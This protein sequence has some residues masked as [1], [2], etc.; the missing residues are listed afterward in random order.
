MRFGKGPHISDEEFFNALDLDRPGLENVRKATQAG[1]WQMAKEAFA[2]HMRRRKHP[3]WKFDWRARPREKAPTYDTTEAE[4]IVRNILTSVSVSHD[5]GPEGNI[6]WELNPINYKEWTWQLSRHPF[7]VTLGEAYWA[8]GDERYTQAFVRQMMHWVTNV[9]RPDDSGNPWR[10]DRTNCWRTI[11][12]G[13]RMGRTWF[14]A[15]YRFLS[16]PHFT[17]EAICMMVKS[18]AEHARHLLKWP[19]SGNWLTM[20]ANGLYHVGVMFP[21]FR[22]AAEWRSVGME[23]LHKELDNQVYPDG[24]QIEL[25]SGY[26]QVSLNNFVWAWEIGQVNQ[27]EIPA[28]YVAKLERMYHYDLYLSMPDGRMPALNDGGY[29]VIKPYMERS[30]AFFP[31]RADFRWA[32]SDGREGRPP[33]VTSCEFPYAG[34]LVTR[35]GWNRDDRYLFFDAGPFGYGHQHEDKLN[36]VL[37]AYG[38][39]LIAD[40][41]NYPYDDSEWRKYVLSTRGHNTIRV[42]GQDQHERGRPRQEYV[43][44]EPLPHT[45]ISGDSFDYAA[46][47]FDQGYG[48]QFSTQPADRTVQ[49][50]RKILFVKPDFWLMADFL[51]SSD[52]AE[53]T[54]ESLFHLDVPAARAT[55]NGVHTLDDG[56]PKLDIHVAASAPL[57][58]QIVSGQ[59]EPEVQGWIPR[60]GPYE[61]QP[62]P[63]AV[64]RARWSGS[65]AIAYLLYPLPAGAGDPLVS[66]KQ[67]V[68]EAGGKPAIGLRFTLTN[69]RTYLYAQRHGRDGLMRWEGYE[70]DAEAALI[71]LRDGRVE[72]AIA[73]DGQFARQS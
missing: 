69:G 21:E 50:H 9:P 47:S 17:P 36:I 42:D 56:G 44:K 13:I 73:A 39:V 62:I 58:K 61:C 57:Q 51:T 16:S 29:T 45:W 49:H 68:V 24:A 35:S 2:A 18:M 70:S 38:K 30:L 37:Y 66:F 64:F 65:M 34:H 1:D 31:R 15:F 53:H 23:R 7:W 11:E 63:T 60:G 19:Q 26:H 41:G 5:F 22:E 25:S 3:L 4:R 54:A 10:E 72:K 20:E 32:A 67:V 48:P 52:E 59:K 71:E 46:A 8:T 43:V 55:K 27:Q 28:D 6:D 40:P 12:C 33:S 14:P